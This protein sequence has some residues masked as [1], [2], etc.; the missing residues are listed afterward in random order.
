MPPV[1]INVTLRN[2]SLNN[3]VFDATDDYAG[4]PLLTAEP[5]GPG[6]S[7]QKQLL[8]APDNY[9]HITYSYKGGVSQT[10]DTVMEG[11]RIDMA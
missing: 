2:S 4:K 3:N 11:D 9:G 10:N 6:D 8:L 5:M 7:V 1:Y